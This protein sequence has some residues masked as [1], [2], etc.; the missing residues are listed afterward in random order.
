[1]S[2]ERVEYIDI[3]RGIGILLVALAHADVS[4]FS[5]YLHRLIY[6]FHMPLFFFLSGYFFNPQ[7]PFW[8]LVKKRFNT[9]LKPYLVTIVL[10]YIASLSFT[11]SPTYALPP[12]LPVLPSPC[13]VQAIT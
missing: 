4:L 1:V 5:P 2:D 11:P 9:I 8:A 10:I 13:M 7:T 3:A 12:Y 6:S